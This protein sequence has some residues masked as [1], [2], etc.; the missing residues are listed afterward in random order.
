[1]KIGT[2]DFVKILFPRFKF[3]EF[4]SSRFG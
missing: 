1:M 4:D 2:F 3:S